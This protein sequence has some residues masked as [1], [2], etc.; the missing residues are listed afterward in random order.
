MPTQYLNGKL[1]I[2]TPEN[3]KPIDD[4]TLIDRLTVKEHPF[5]A[6]S[7]DNLKAT[8]MLF[9][10]NEKLCIENFDEV[11]NQQR[12]YF[13]RMTPGYAEFGMPRKELNGRMNQCLIYKQNAPDGGELFVTFYLTHV[14][15]RMLFGLFSCPFENRE[16]LNKIV[17]SMIESITIE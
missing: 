4:E 16:K 3:W 13:V 17:M 2:N 10:P 9:Y 11:F 1:T 15:E 6:I 8:C 7:S 14:D 12:T 5:L